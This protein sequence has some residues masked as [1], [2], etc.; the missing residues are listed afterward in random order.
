MVYE[1]NRILEIIEALEK[2][3]SVTVNKPKGNKE[4]VEMSMTT[5]S[6]KGPVE[7]NW[8]GTEIILPELRGKKMEYP[9]AIEV[10]TRKMAEEEQKVDIFNLL[11]CSPLD[12]AVAFMRALNDVFGWTE[13]VN[14]KTM[15]GEQPP[16]LVTVQV[17]P[18]GETIQ[19]PFGEMKV[20]GMDAVFKTGIDNKTPGFIIGGWTKRKHEPDIKQIVAL[21]EK[22]LRE[23]SIYKRQAV[24]INYN[25][26]REQRNFHP[27]NDAPQYMPLNDKVESSLVFS[28]EV[29][30]QLNI[31]LFAPIEYKAACRK[32]QVPLKRGVLLYGPYGT[33]KTLTATVTAVKA[34]RAGWTFVYLEDVRDL[35]EGLQFAARYAPAI[36][37][38]ED[39]DRAMSGERSVQMDAI[40]NTLDGVDTKNGEVITVF[41]TN[42]IETI[43]PAVL[44]MGRL[45]AL[46]EVRPPDA[47]AAGRL[48]HFYARGLLAEGTNIQPVSSKLAGK[49]P[50]FIRE[51][52]ERAKI[53]AICRLG[54]GD[55]EGHVEEQDLLDAT[56]ALERHNDLLRPKAAPMLPSSTQ[57]QVR[58]DS[59][60]AMAQEILGNF[61]NLGIANGHGTDED[62]EQEDA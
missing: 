28:K 41:T 1:R 22:N 27:L 30:A 51:V 31:G 34:V 48:V 21:T 55:I 44:R 15:F 5:A 60:H 14:T 56:D 37:F 57:V 53:A 49:I 35:K 50:A 26:I 9:T 10:L 16:T 36:L 20:P 39:I 7:V 47:E 17:G 61:K 29:S 59:T 25:Y 52:T 32:Y 38:A 23:R 4:M 33:G 45:D 24:K 54:G 11:P 58:L 62:D 18:N 8:R 40:L 6:I 12:G 19:V 3:Q 42:H 13:L 2:A 43:N 46:I